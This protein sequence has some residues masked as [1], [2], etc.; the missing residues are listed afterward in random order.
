MLFRGIN[1]GGNKIVRMEKLREMLTEAGFGN[2]A[3][4]IQ[5]GNVLFEA[6]GPSQSELTSQVESALSH[7]FNYQSWVV[8]RSHE[9]MQQ[10]V[11]RAPE[12]V[13]P[14]LPTG[15]V[16]VAVRELTVQSAAEALPLPVNSDTELPEETRLRYRFLDLRR[17]AVHRNIVLLSQVIASIRRRMIAAGVPVV[18]GGQDPLPDLAVHLGLEGFR[19]GKA[20]LG[21]QRLFA[22]GHLRIDSRADP[23]AVVLPRLEL[24][25]DEVRELVVPGRQPRAG[26]ARPTPM[27]G[28]VPDHPAP[29]LVRVSVA[30]LPEETPQASVAE[31]SL[32]ELRPVDR[33]GRRDDVSKIPLEPR[34]AFAGI[35]AEEYAKLATIGVPEEHFERVLASLPFFARDILEADL[36]ARAEPLRLTWRYHLWQAMAGEVP[37]AAE[38]RVIDARVQAVAAHPGK[39]DALAPEL[40]EL[41]RD[42]VQ[43]DEDVAPGTVLLRD[44]SRSIIATNE[45]P[46]VGFDASVNP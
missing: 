33:L 31:R 37:S 36:I 39:I 12:A 41:V 26:P 2:V 23:E 1:V 19:S 8:L 29:L 17:E 13:N 44:S 5:S 10:V 9:Q 15:E 6:D 38:R 14:R 43:G 34:Q 35:F 20:E 28:D 27:A 32:A 24:A 46:D 3:T 25:N 42:A 40:F 22:R 16:E 4:Y 7:A 21:P 18:P 11:A 45:S 30:D